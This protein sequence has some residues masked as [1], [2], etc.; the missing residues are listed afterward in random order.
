MVVGLVEV[1][2]VEGGGGP[3]ETTMFTELPGATEDPGAGVDEMTTPAA[4][5]AE[6]CGVTVP[7]FSPA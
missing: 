1:V 4:Y 5:W 7:T 3:D 2:V 6:G